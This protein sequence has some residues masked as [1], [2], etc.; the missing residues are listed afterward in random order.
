MRCYSCNKEFIRE[1]WYYKKG[2][3]WYC[4]KEEMSEANVGMKESDAKYYMERWDG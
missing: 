1:N 2:G 4:C 3:Y